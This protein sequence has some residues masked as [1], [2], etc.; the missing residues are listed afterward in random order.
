MDSVVEDL[1]KELKDKAILGVIDVDQRPLF[2][3]F[4]IRGIP[5]FMIY[6]DGK[7]ATRF[8]GG[9]SKDALR[10]LILK[11]SVAKAGEM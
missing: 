9:V 5:H 10:S 6:R 4:G 7:L 3:K 11:Y 2:V 8:T 1:A